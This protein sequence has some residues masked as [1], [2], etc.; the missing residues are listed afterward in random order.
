MITMMDLN[1]GCITEHDLFLFSIKTISQTS[2]KVSHIICLVL[3][4]LFLDLTPFSEF[5][6][7]V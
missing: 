6:L 4:V 2:N 1:E 5:K 3:R 7:G